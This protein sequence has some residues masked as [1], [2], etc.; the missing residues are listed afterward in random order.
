MSC[1][2]SPHQLV[3]NAALQPAL[4]LANPPSSAAH[5]QPPKPQNLNPKPA[6]PRADSFEAEVHTVWQWLDDGPEQS[7]TPRHWQ[8]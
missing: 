6:E 8:T 5:G 3:P 2:R 1:K 7:W 4:V